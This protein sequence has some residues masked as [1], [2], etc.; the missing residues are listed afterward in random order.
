MH[1]VIVMNALCYCYECVVIVMNALCYCY[2][3]ILKIQPT[4]LNFVCIVCAW[5]AVRAQRRHLESLAESLGITRYEQW[6]NVKVRT[7]KQIGGEKLLAQYQQSLPKCLQTVYPEFQWHPWLFKHSQKQFWK[8]GSNQRECTSWMEKELHINTQEDWYKVTPQQLK[9]SGVY[10]LLVTQNQSVIKMLSS[11]YPQYKWYSWLFTHIPKP[12]LYWKKQSTQRKYLDW[13]AEELGIE[14]SYDFYS[15]SGRTVCKYFGYGIMEANSHSMVRLLK[16]AY[17]EYEWCA[18]LLPNSPKNFWDSK[19]NQREFLDWFCSEHGITAPEE[20]Y[21]HSVQDLL[22]LGAAPLLQ[23]YNLSLHKML[24]AVYPHIQ[25]HSYLF[26][27]VPKSHWEDRAM[28]RSF[29]DWFAEEQHISETEQWYSVSA[30]MILA[31]GG[32]SLLRHNGDSLITAL[33]TLYAEFEWHPWL[34]AATPK[35]FWE[36]VG[37]QRKYCDWLAETLH[38]NQ[39]EDL[40][41]ITQS[42]FNELHGSS[43]LRMY[44]SA[45]HKVL[46]SVYPEFQFFPWLFT[47]TPDSYWDSAE[48]QAAYFN[49]LAYELNI[50]DPSDWYDV[51]SHVIT[52]TGAAGLLQRYHGNLSD[53][54]LA[55]YPQYPWQPEKFTQLPVTHHRKYMNWISEEYGV[56]SAHDWYALTTRH[57]REKG[58]TAVLHHYG[59]SLLRLLQS[60]YPEFEWLPWKFRR[61][62]Y[63]Y[64]QEVRHQ[65]QCLEHI[66]QQLGFKDVLQWMHVDTQTVKRLGGSG[67]LAYFGGSLQKVLTSVYPEI[68]WPSRAAHLRTRQLNVWNFVRRAVGL[69]TELEYRLYLNR[70]LVELDVYIPSLALAFEYQGEQ[71]YHSSFHSNVQYKQQLL[72]DNHK[73]QLCKQLGITL[74]HIPYWWKDSPQLL[75]STIL[76]YRP[77]VPIH[78]SYAPSLLQAKQFYP[79]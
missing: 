39:Q 28:Q 71:H 40:Y 68:E 57:L 22:Q 67:L 50:N 48:N 31:S 47:H 62:P 53:A 72:R 8:K 69:R 13:L 4:V 35:H 37:N 73:M 9:E 55:I 29:L 17:P 1:C 64:W 7:L 41:F 70:E 19:E 6:Y 63:S 12:K 66:Q 30:S 38:V 59:H 3:C 32:A 60:V 18:W 34:F 42:D 21:L 11:L 23:R 77:D 27:N 79:E 14:L 24:R 51:S 65:K 33:Q 25:W 45:V 44:D 78:P 76:K 52:S 58:A 26:A 16:S 74:V 43:L 10:E 36:R 46:Q 61:S 15:V 5:M 56:Q 75:V 54:L 49:W 20:W 2:E